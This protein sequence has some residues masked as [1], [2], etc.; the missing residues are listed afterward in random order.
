MDSINDDRYE[1]VLRRHLKYLPDGEPLTADA[2]LKEFGLDSMASVDLLFDMEDTFGIV[3][4][5]DYLVAETF[6]TPT[7]LRH[8]VN[9]VG[10]EVR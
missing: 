10:G 4:P 8:A 2:D 9:E 1:T 3:V 7:T 6:A 5:D